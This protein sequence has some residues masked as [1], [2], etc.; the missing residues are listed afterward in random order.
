MQPQERERGRTTV[1]RCVGRDE[2]AAHQGPAPRHGRHGLDRRLHPDQIKGIGALEVLAAT[3]LIVS[4]VLDLVP[5]LTPIAAAGVVLLMIGAGA[6][7]AR[8]GEWANVPV[9]VVLAAV[10]LFIAIERFGPHA[11]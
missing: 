3:G 7:H 5:I 1:P 9:N 8:R 11:L 6:T 4:A 10:A 2:A